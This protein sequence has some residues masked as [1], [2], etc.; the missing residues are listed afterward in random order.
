MKVVIRIQFLSPESLLSRKLFW[1]EKHELFEKME[2]EGGQI[3]V[4]AR[5]LIQIKLVAE[6]V[7]SVH[8]QVGFVTHVF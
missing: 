2:R 3:R 7:L 6:H 4:V 1:K 8:F 5:V